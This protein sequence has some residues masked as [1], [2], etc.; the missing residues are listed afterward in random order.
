[1][2]VCLSTNNPHMWHSIQLQKNS[3]LVSIIIVET[4]LAL[5]NFPKLTSIK[6][7]C[8]SLNQGFFHL[9]KFLRSPENW[10]IIFQYEMDLYLFNRFN[11]FSLKVKLQCDHVITIL[12]Y[13]FQLMSL[14]DQSLI[15]IFLQTITLWVGMT[16]YP[17][18]PKMKALI[19]L[20]DCYTWNGGMPNCPNT[21][22]SQNPSQ[23]PYIPLD[24]FDPITSKDVQIVL[25]QHLEP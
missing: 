23:H 12:F 15:T 8:L 6:L 2:F 3:F 19:W 21:P 24:I 4:Y 9:I 11:S 16:Y 1:V 7:C 18:C 20:L 5:N 22:T 13:A 14:L 17:H 25:L 10:I